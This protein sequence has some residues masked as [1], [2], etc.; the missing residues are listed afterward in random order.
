MPS[1]HLLHVFPTFAVGGSQIRFAQLARL[2]GTR[3]RHTVIALD[4]NTDMAGRLT[5]LP[6]TCHE[7]QFDKRKIFDS[8]RRFRATLRA[9]RPDVLF[10]YNWGAVEWALINRLEGVARH[11]HV[12]DG[13]GPEE[14]E[15]QLLRRIWT[16]RLALSGKSTVVV[17]PSRNLEQIALDRWSLSPD[18]VRFVPNG[19]DCTRYAVPTRTIASGRT[20]IGT[21]ASLR[22]EKNIARLMRAFAELA[23]GRQDGALELLIV[24]DGVERD[25]LERLARE[26]NLAGR[27]RFAGQ[28]DR[29]EDWY[30]RMDIF[31]LS[32]DTEQM[33]LS[34][35]EAMAAGLPVVAT[36]VGDVAQMVSEENRKFVVPVEEFSTALARLA[37]DG[38]HQRKIGLAN[39]R[40]A[41]E[42]FDEKSMAERYAALIG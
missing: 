2:L 17:L 6:V 37:G 18:R 8:W 27:V 7:L 10:T 13:F 23:G 9:I 1:K 41:R 24:G 32:S 15:K 36:A 21:V 14:A 30:P 22:P 34:V 26:L 31:A 33:P 16:R 11:I 35:L 3:H 28:S 40:K 29:P 19:V 5:G 42:S 39:E 25:G 4:G 20:V 12:E 38:T